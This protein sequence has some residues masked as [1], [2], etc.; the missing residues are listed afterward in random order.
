MRQMKRRISNI[1]GYHPATRLQRTAGYLVCLLVLL[2]AV[3]FTSILPARTAYGDS[4]TS[5][6]R[7]K[8]YLLWT[9]PGIWRDGRLFRPV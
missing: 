4:D 3:V 1:A 5:A 9:F 7:I 2:A 6:F 8:R